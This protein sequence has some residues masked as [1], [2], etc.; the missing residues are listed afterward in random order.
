M[1]WPLACAR[2]GQSLR[3]V[4]VRAAKM[5]H[6][7]VALST[8]PAASSYFQRPPAEKGPGHSTARLTV[9]VLLAEFGSAVT[10]VAVALSVITVPAEAV[11]FTVTRSVHVVFGAIALFSLQMICPVPWYGGCV[12]VPS[13]GVPE[14]RM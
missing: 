7:R 8:A 9:A 4:R 5:Y 6:R 1:P 11:T 3:S 2:A 13:P 12:H 14:M 10:S